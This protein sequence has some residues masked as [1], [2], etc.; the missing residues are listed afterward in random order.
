MFKMVT[1]CALALA[2]VVLA[3][4][5]A[6]QEEC[7]SETG[8]VCG[9]VWNDANNNGIQNLGETG[10]GDIQVS[11]SNGTDTFSTSTD[12][13]GFFYFFD[14]NDP[15]VTT[16]TLSIETSAIGT[17]AVASTPNVGSDDTID[18][19]GT[20]NGTT[21]SVS[22]Q[23]TNSDYDF[24]FYVPSAQSSLGTG[25]PGYWK[26]HPEAWPDTITIGG[27][28][29]SRDD[30]IYWLKRVGK[31][32]TTTMFSSLV[33]AKLNVLIGNVSSCVTTTITRADAWMAT[34]GPVGSNVAA[35]S[36]AWAAGQPLHMTLDDYNN[37]RL[38][39]P[40]RN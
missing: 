12:S 6:A 38:C 1:A 16:Y 10:L 39:A 8:M 34:N 17:T 33:S 26:N 11:L 40:H 36:P 28:T 23:V 21:S 27:I 22:F 29:Y 2:S 32:K 7:R 14:V 18:S 19:D 5:A 37:G 3:T 20:S 15:N 9:F 31:D 24:G 30:A 35:S 4:P 13:S 25:T